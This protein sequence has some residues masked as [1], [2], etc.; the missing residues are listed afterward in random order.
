MESIGKN[1]RLHAWA[2]HRAYMARMT[3]CTLNSLQIETVQPWFDQCIG[4]DS[5]ERQFYTKEVKRDQIVSCLYKNKKKT[6]A[7]GGECK[8]GPGD[9]H[10]KTYK[11]YSNVVF[12][13]QGQSSPHTR[14]R[15]IQ[16]SSQKPG[17]LGPRATDQ[18]PSQSQRS[19]SLAYV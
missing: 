6:R 8:V 1:Q 9:G 4:L 19:L 16:R 18:S 17:R 15:N 14:L 13:Q 11:Q 5:L 3:V 2:K 10:T 12:R 7:G